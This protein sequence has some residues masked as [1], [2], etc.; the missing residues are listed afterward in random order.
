MKI[1]RNLG[2]QLAVIFVVLA[3]CYFNKPDST[4]MEKTAYD[5][6]S[7]MLEWHTKAEWL[8]SIG[9]LIFVTSLFNLSSGFVVLLGSFA[10]GLGIAVF[11]AF[12]H[13]NGI[14]MAIL[15][16]GIMICIICWFASG[17]IRYCS[18]ETKNFMRC[19]CVVG[20]AMAF[21]GY[22]IKGFDVPAQN[23]SPL[24]TENFEAK[25]KRIGDHPE[26]N[27][28]I[29]I[30]VPG[31]STQRI[32][33][34]QGRTKDVFEEANRLAKEFKVGKISHLDNVSLL[35]I[36]PEHARKMGALNW[37]DSRKHDSHYQ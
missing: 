12:W 2:L 21:L 23:S 6:I 18:N 11:G 27:W 9:V 16:L 7:F 28:W 8:I 33:R 17:V 3:L 4:S 20:I 31:E 24:K 32:Y 19:F 25:M 37:I 15:A 5:E 36:P 10:T 1:L 26:A 22:S 13:I 30:R 14:G 34:F 35:N 29:K